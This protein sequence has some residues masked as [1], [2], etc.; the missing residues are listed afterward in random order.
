MTNA[1]Q[2]EEILKQ[3]VASVSKIDGIVAIV[4]G[5]SRARGTA[6]D[7]SDIDLGIYYDAARPFSTVAL[8]AAAQD[9]DDRQPAVEVT[10]DVGVPDFGG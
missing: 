10:L 8:G 5:G 6:D 7:R 9:L 3:V 4:L 1:E 2:I